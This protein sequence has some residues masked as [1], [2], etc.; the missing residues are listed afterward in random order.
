MD[1]TGER[2]IPSLEERQIRYE[3]LQ[4]Y[5]SVREL[6]HGKVVVDAAAGEG[7][8]SFIL[9][10]SATMVTGIDIDINS[11]NEAQ[12]KYKK[13]NLEYRFGSID[14]LPFPDGSV[15]VLIS[16]ETIEHV[17]EEMQRRFLKEIKRILKADGLLVISTPNK[18]V[19]SDMRD[20]RNPFHIKEFYVEEFESFLKEFFTEIKIYH[21]KN[22]VSSVMTLFSQ[23]ENVK[24]INLDIMEEHAPG[25]YVVAVCSNHH[26]QDAALGSNILFPNE[27]QQLMNR[28]LTLQKEVDERNYH[29]ANLDQHIEELSNSIRAYQ[30]NEINHEKILKENQELYLE[31][32]KTIQE[33]NIHLHQLSER[34]AAQDLQLKE[35][36]AREEEYQ[37][38]ISQQK[39]EIQETVQEFTDILRN[40]DAHII[41]LLKQERHLNNI[42]QS[43]GWRFLKAYYK[44]RDSIIPPNSKRK[45]FSK[46]ASKTI[47]NPKSMISNL[48]RQNI[49]KLKYYLKVEDN[50][51]IENRIDHFLERNENSI[52]AEIKLVSISSE[53]SKL[54]FPIYEDPDVSIIIPV[55]NQWEYTYS[56]L[57]SILS[58]TEGVRYE[59]IIADDM[60]T[61]ETTEMLTYVEN[62]IIVRDGENRG[63]LLN[64]NNAA[65]YAKGEFLFFLN[66]DT[67]VQ[68]NWLSSLLELMDSDEKIGMTGSKLVYPDGRL[69][70]AGGIIWNDASG[71]NYGRLD[72]PEKPEYNYVKEVDY[73]SGAAILIR[74]HLWVKI[75]GFDKRY[76]PAYFEDSDLAFEVRRQGYK[77]TLQPKSVV[78]HFEGISHGT[79]TETGTKSYQVLNKAKF[80]DKW[81]N[82]LQAVQ[83][84]NGEH[85]FLARDRSRTKKTILFID[86]YIPHFDKDAGSKTV[87]QYI[88]LFCK[89]GFNVKFIGD[90]FFKHEPYTT[91]LENLG[92][93]VLHGNWYFKNWKN[94]LK[95]NGAYLDFIWLNRPHISEKYIGA[96]KQLTSAKVIYY[97]HDLHYLREYR[98]FQ[99]TGNPALRQSA[100]QWEKIELDL[101]A[102]ADL[103]YYP[104]EVEVQELKS[105]NPNLNVKAI[106]AY[107]YDEQAPLQANWGLR[108]D[109]LF[110]GGFGHKPNV[111]AILWF[112][113]KVWPLIIKKNADL[114]F[115]VVGSNPPDVIKDLH[116][117]QVIV[118]GF[119][120]DEELSRYYNQ[121]KIAVVPLR[122]GA[123]VKGKVVEAL[124]HQLP[125]VTTGVGAEGLPDIT[126][127]L[128]ICDEPEIM[129]E[130]IVTLYNDN[131]LL[132]NLSVKSQDYIGRYFSTEHVIEVIET[133]FN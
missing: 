72:D 65:Q 48:N 35:L 24:Q 52:S 133:D 5:L 39:R 17:N 40:K 112:I 114:C 127:Y 7:Y 50:S 76:A 118:T 81:K 43:D 75:G 107:I 102:K 63:F 67:N 79:S 83:F 131:E 120:S 45:L 91:A 82:E 58:N 66:N 29:L 98:E 77:V 6:V 28:I 94:W 51:N 92:V 60:S 38:I 93:E 100:E 70:E 10:Q 57:A 14:D 55:Y 9:S 74:R 22:E 104:S 71:W 85:V 80:I 20:H 31:K 44:L 8:G 97:G 113:D 111:D 33:L 64:C 11:I 61:D 116:S 96:I 132:Q 42:L 25:M 99:L 26:L 117:K 41:E 105:K 16:F 121:C 13:S 56:C 88:K 124:Y 49:K 3:H 110:V 126:D 37:R 4:R 73:I 108:K 1:F 90:N 32:E 59:I 54:L 129:A 12:N 18:S 19:Y 2:F 27:Y 87:F 89:L 106:P 46:M 15:D 119:V 30:Q 122:F 47:R 62:I 34:N 36:L 130:Q 23:E 123:G 69:Q 78:V 84:Q 68:E 128:L 86:H 103:V 21:Q 101:C 125:I 53:K 109:L 95:N 115:Y